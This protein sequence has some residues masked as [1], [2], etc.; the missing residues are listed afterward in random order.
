VGSNGQQVGLLGDE[1]P[2]LLLVLTLLGLVPG[3][4]GEPD[5]FSPVVVDGADDDT[6][7]ELTPILARS[8]PVL[9]ELSLAQGYLEVVL[10]VPDPLFLQRIEDPEGST[11][12]L[13]RRVPLDALRPLVLAD[14]VSLHVEHEDR[15]LADRAHQES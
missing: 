15:V 6:R 1:V 12:D 2:A 9:D 7:P 4:L 10:W 11:D 3:D 8:P 5:V 13:L 14:D